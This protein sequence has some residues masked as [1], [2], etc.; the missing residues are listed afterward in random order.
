MEASLG[1]SSGD[2]SLFQSW[3]PGVGWAIMGMSNIYIYIGKYRKKIFKSLLEK[4]SAKN[5]ET[6]VK[7]RFVQI[8]VRPNHDS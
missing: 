6:C 8:K 2:S 4:H 5:A 1:T 7:A 3:T